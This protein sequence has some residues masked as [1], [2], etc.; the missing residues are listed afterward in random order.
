MSRAAFRVVVQR[1]SCG[2]KNDLTLRKWKLT[3]ATVTF[4]RKAKKLETNS[5]SGSPRLWILLS[6]CVLHASNAL[7]ISFCSIYGV[8]FNPSRVWLQ[9]PVLTMISFLMK[10]H[11][12]LLIFC[13]QVSTYDLLP[14]PQSSP[15]KESFMYR[16]S[17]KILLGDLS[18]YRNQKNTYQVERGLAGYIQKDGRKRCPLRNERKP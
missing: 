2:Q 7:I 8:I 11:S 10:Y 16:I 3:D 9:F 13:C 1:K 18:F 15:G 5:N 14:L 12:L 4:K 6:V 17:W